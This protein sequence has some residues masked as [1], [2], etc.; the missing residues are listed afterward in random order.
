L[1]FPMPQFTNYWESLIKN[2]PNKEWIDNLDE[3]GFYEENFSQV[4]AS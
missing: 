4:G 1:N 2:G 3:F